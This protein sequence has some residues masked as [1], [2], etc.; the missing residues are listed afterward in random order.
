[1]K[2]TKKLRFV[3]PVLALTTLLLAAV[4]FVEKTPGIPNPFNPNETP[5]QNQTHFLVFTGS[6]TPGENAKT[7][8]AYYNAIDPAPHQKRTFPEWLK[9]NGFI[10]DVSQWHPYGPQIIACD[11]GTANG[12]DIRAHDALGNPVPCTQ[13]TA[14]GLTHKPVSGF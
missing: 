5:F 6:D 10:G 2:I 3:L 7:A 9:A 14:P 8:T 12:C 11:L 4:N 13:C 1:M